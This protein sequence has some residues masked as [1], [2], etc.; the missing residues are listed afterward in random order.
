MGSVL[1]S[2]KQSTTSE[3]NGFANLSEQDLEKILEDKQSII[4]S[5]TQGSTA[6]ISVQQ[7]NQA[8]VESA[9][10]VEN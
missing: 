3:N 7:S 2:T 6:L 10:V 9:S 5:P 4:S 1:R 8:A